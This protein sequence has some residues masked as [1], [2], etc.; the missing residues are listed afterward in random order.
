VWRLTA[1]AFVAPPGYRDASLALSGTAYTLT[2]SRNKAQTSVDGVALARN[3]AVLPI[4]RAYDEV[5]DVGDN[6]IGP[7]LAVALSQRNIGVVTGSRRVTASGPGAIGGEGVPE[8]DACSVAAL[9]HSSSALA[10]EVATACSLHRWIGL[11]T[12]ISLIPAADGVGARFT[13]LTNGLAGVSVWLSPGLPTELRLW[14]LSADGRTLGTLVATSTP[15]NVD[16]NGLTLF[17]FA[18]IPDS[19]GRS[20]VFTLSCTDCSHPLIPRMVAFKAFRG[21]PDLVEGGARLDPNRVAAFSLVYQSL[22]GADRSQTTVQ[23]TSLGAGQWRLRTSG[24][25]PSLVVLAES[26]FPGWSARVDGKAAAVVEADGA[27]LGVV[28]GPGEHTIALAFHRPGIAAVGRIITGLTLAVCLLLLWRP[29]RRPRLG[30][31]RHPDDVV[32]QNGQAPG[33]GV[34]ET[35]QTVDGRRPKVGGRAAEERRPDGQ[36]VL[37]R[38]GAEPLLVRD[39]QSRVRKRP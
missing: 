24:S 38:E 5:L 28:V 3:P 34:V 11:S 23:A 37:V 16:P 10:G 4:A 17:P 18:P 36:G 9:A 15:S 1:E 6:G 27:F 26:W 8:A 22:P 39:G 20:Y 21:S 31:V 7:E 2:E 35:G 32:S 14:E 13:P 33:Q 25:S 12:G 29:G 30:A 19:A